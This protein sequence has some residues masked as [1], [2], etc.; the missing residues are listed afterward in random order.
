MCNG[1]QLQGVPKM[2]PRL[3]SYDELKSKGIHHSKTQIWRL[4]KTGAFP[5]RVQ[6]TPGR[7]GWLE[8]EIDQWIESKIAERNAKIERERAIITEVA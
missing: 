8:G 6:L 2:R 1:Q 5:R 4:E 7:V 3:L